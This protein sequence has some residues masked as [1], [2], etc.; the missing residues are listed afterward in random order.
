MSLVAE[1]EPAAPVPPDDSTRG[2]VAALIARILGRPSVPVDVSLFHLGG[3]SLDAARLCGQFETEFG[4][5]V[6]PSQVF[7][8]PSAAGLA[9]W[10]DGL[11]AQSGAPAGTAAVAAW[12]SLLEQPWPG[13]GPAPATRVPLLPHQYM[14][15]GGT[16]G[17][18]SAAICPLLW[19]IDGPVD[20]DALA[21]ALGDLHRRH[22]A[23]HASYAGAVAGVPDDPGSPAILRLAGAPSEEAAR[24]AVLDALLRPLAV[25]RGE[26]WRA[27]WAP[28]AGTG[29]L[30]FGIVL[31]HIAFDGWSQALLAADLSTAYAARAAGSAPVFATASASLT[32][33]A[34]E[35]FRGY[36]RSELATSRAYWAEA[37]RDLPACRLPGRRSSDAGA[38]PVYQARAV[39]PLSTLADWYAFAQRAG[40]T[41]F[42]AL[43]AAYAIAVHRVTGQPD[44][45][46]LVPV[47]RRGT[48]VLDPT[49]MCRVDVVC[50]RMS[51]LDDGFLDAAVRA[52]DRG[53]AAQ[54]VPFAE[55][56][57]IPSA[58]ALQSAP[59]FALQ[60]DPDPELALP[61]CRTAVDPVQLPTASADLYFTLQ[62]LD[63]TRL[64]VVADVRTDR[65]PP[66]VADEVVAAYLAII[67][68]GPA[69][70]T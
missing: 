4:V 27:A 68:E 70:L 52:V 40:T 17:T 13:P 51:G 39:L 3:T 45:G 26:V 47:A 19:W 2:R 23:L 10:Y 28:V 42:A 54:D 43:A 67:E 59:W 64:S 57:Q 7:R 35:Y 25:D 20:R 37:L 49:I 60:D 69:A 44:F 1:S 36:R 9:E 16:G 15:A 22:Q 50:L 8:T 61:G 63:D 5:A 29:R 14:W 58:E 62:R 31:H 53:L 33:V 66:A 30:A 24:A 65:V 46:V 56:A 12:R 32:E 55:V 48:G 34:A 18:D 41:R 11:G 38:G 6:T 21:L